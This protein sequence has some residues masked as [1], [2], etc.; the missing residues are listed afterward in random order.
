MRETKSILALPFVLQVNHL[1]GRRP[2]QHFSVRGNGNRSKWRISCGAIVGPVVACGDGV[3]L[4]D[5]VGDGD[6]DG[7]GVGNGLAE[8]L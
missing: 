4:R 5:V 1:L 7:D 2:Q 8:L 6:G 3:A